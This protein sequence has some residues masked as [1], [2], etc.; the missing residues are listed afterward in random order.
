M[1]PVEWLRRPRHAT[2]SQ[3]LLR[4]L[5]AVSGYICLGSRHFSRYVTTKGLSNTMSP[6]DESLQAPGFEELRQGSP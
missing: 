1:H 5:P 2:R 6:N 4:L 3:R